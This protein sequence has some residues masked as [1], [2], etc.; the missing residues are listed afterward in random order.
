[1]ESGFHVDLAQV[2]LALRESPVSGPTGGGR[3]LHV[4]RVHEE[5]I[6]L[7]RVRDQSERAVMLV[8]E[9][10]MPILVTT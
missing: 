10:K 3:Q 6:V 5:G 1:M 8:D 7:A 4:S 2:Q 9:K